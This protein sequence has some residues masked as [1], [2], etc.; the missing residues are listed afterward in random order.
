MKTIV[1]TTQASKEIDALPLEAKEAVERAL[2]D[3]AVHRRGDV[4]KLRGRENDSR[5]RVGRYRVIFTE[6]TMTILAIYV[7]KRDSQTY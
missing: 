1:F 2:N 3:Y 5:L 6:S 4:K 7:G